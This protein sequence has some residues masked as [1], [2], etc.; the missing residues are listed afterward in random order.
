MK[1]RPAT[2]ADLDLL[3]AWDREPHVAAAGGTDPGWD[4]P[5]ELERGAP[6]REML[7]AATDRR[8]VGFVQILDPA[9][10]P[11]RYWGDVPEPVRA[12]DI[13]IGSA[14]DLGRGFGTRMMHLTLDRCFA[15][16]EVAAVLVDPLASNTRVHRFYRRFG[17]KPVERRVFD[18]EP[19][20]V[21]RLDR[22]DWT[23]PT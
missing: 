18:R 8:P 4:W 5:V 13:W 6:G 22:L 10:D 14:A 21:H 16:P 3:Q 15:V 2:P 11:D 19:C 1:L 17:F 23:G 12:V 9:R 20:L 7:I